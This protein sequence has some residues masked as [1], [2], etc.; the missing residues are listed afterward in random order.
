MVEEVIYRRSKMA[1]DGGGGSRR[2]LEERRLGLIYRQ[3]RLGAAMGEEMRNGRCWVSWKGEL[4]RS[5]EL[6][7]RR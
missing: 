5:N 3:G 4:V 7:R 1:S 6:V 2:R